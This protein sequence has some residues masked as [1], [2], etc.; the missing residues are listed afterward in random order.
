MDPVTTVESHNVYEAGWKSHIVHASVT[1]QVDGLILPMG[2]DIARDAVRTL[3]LQ[4]TY[5][6]AS[7]K[8][9]ERLEELIP[10]FD[11]EGSQ[12]HIGFAWHNKK[13]ISFSLDN[14][15]G[16]S[17]GLDASEDGQYVLLTAEG[18]PNRSLE[19]LAD[20]KS[21][22]KSY[23][24][25]DLDL[26]YSVFGKAIRVDLGDLLANID[27]GEN[28]PERFAGQMND[29]NKAGTYI[30][31]DDTFGSMTCTDIDDAIYFKVSINGTHMR[32]NGTV[33]T[34]DVLDYEH[35][36][37]GAKIELV[38]YSSKGNRDY[39]ARAEVSNQ[40]HD[41]MKTLVSNTGLKF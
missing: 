14:I 22:Q 36:D 11:L 39:A 24:R 27:V 1:P 7:S 17:V 18:V 35:W 23:S 10:E 31:G 26:S 33:V 38:R 30:A 12:S 2:N 15:V 9:L 29:F 25:I 6:D 13:N 37:T 32:P 41:I 28:L 3:L 16:Y 19:M 21:L 5:L 4:F 8:E 40:M 20:E 34:G